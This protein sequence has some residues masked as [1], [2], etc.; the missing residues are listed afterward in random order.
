VCAT[1]HE[2]QEQQNSKTLRR[3]MSY[4]YAILNCTYPSGL[5]PNPICRVS[6]TVE[7]YG[8]F[9]SIFY[10]YLASADAAG[11]LQE[12]VGAALLNFYVSVYGQLWPLPPPV[13]VPQYLLVNAQATFGTGP[14]PQPD[15]P[16]ASVIALGSWIS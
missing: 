12:A 16:L 14:L 6:G 5:D 1:Q 2:Q 11:Q 7:G 9:P 13:P 15:I 3:T 10:Q 8:C 4:D